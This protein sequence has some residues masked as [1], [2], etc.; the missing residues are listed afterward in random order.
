[1]HAQTFRF[2]NEWSGIEGLSYTKLCRG[3]SST[4]RPSLPAVPKAHRCA[5]HT[6]LSALVGALLLQF[7]LPGGP[8][9]I[10]SVPGQFP[11]LQGLVRSPSLEATATRPSSRAALHPVISQHVVSVSVSPQSSNSSRT[12]A[13][14]INSFPYPR[15]QPS[16]GT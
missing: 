10:P 6:P 7:C 12:D 11:R 9:P 8:S 4:S 3:F 1:M 5:Q 2:V 16:H 13:L 15:N 14:L